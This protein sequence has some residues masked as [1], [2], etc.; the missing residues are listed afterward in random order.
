MAF[1]DPITTPTATDTRLAGLE[2]VG[3]VVQPGGDDCEVYYGTVRTDAAGHIC[4]DVT[5]ASF[6]V[7]WAKIKDEVIDGISGAQVAA[8]LKKIGKRL[9]RERENKTP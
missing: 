2:R 6:R 3:V 1:D 4:S 7:P 8:Y 9:A 5:R